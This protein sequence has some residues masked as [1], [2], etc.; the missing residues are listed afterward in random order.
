MYVK[1]LKDNP[2]PAFYCENRLH[3]SGIPTICIYWLLATQ[4]CCVNF[5]FPYW[6]K[7]QA[8]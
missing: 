8:H 2:H 5:S 4:L 7:K 3:A 1:Y 6:R